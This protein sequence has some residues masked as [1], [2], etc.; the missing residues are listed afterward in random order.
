MKPADPLTTILL[1]LLTPASGRGDL[2]SECVEVPVEVAGQP[3]P[4]LEVRLAL[5]AFEPD[6]RDLADRPPVAAGLGDELDRELEAGVGLDADLLHERAV[7]GLERARRVVRPDPGEPAEREPGPARERRLQRTARRSAGRP[8]CSGSPRPR[9]RPRSIEPGE[10]V[11]LGRVVGAVGHRD[12]HDRRRR[13]RRCR[14]GSRARAR[15]RRCSASAR[16]A[17]RRARTSPRT[18]ASCRPASRTPRGS[19]TAA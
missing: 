12:D 16:R 7:V 15:A 3:L 19:R 5:R 1:M 18:A 14:S 13:V 17:G 2:R 10:L 4:H 11:D 8:A 9:P 6:R